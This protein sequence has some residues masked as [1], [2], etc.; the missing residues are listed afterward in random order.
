MSGRNRQGDWG[1]FT[2]R[3][4]QPL[5]PGGAA[6]QRRGTGQRRRGS[7][8]GGDAPD[9]PDLASRG[10][11]RQHGA[12]VPQSRFG[13]ANGGGRS[14]FVAILVLVVAAVIVAI[15]GIAASQGDSAAGSGATVSISILPF[16]QNTVTTATQ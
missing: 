10:G 1:E 3:A 6:G 13:Q 14:R 5:G 12:R 9:Y 4:R 7:G 8:R 16:P 2:E 11:Y 15:G